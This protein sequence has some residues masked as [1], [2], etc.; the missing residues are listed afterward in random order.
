MFSIIMSFRYI[1]T[2]A[3]AMITDKLNYR[4]AFYPRS[5]RQRCTLRHVIPLYKVNPLFTIYKSHVIGG[6]PNTI[7]RAHFQTPCYH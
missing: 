7:L 2:V 3:S 5:S 4:H 6:E 1:G